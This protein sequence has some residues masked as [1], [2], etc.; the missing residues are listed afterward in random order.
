MPFSGPTN[1]ERIKSIFRAFNGRAEDM[2]DIGAGNGKYG[3]FALGLMPDTWRVGV[4]IT[5][6]YIAKYELETLYNE[7]LNIDA[8]QLM[9][10]PD[11]SWDLVC[12]GDVI[13][14]MRRSQAL[15]L[16]HFLAY[17][18]KWMLIAYPEKL[19]QNSWGGHVEEAHISSW[20]LGDFD[21]MDLRY[22]RV[23]VKRQ[24][25]DIYRTILLAQGFRES[26]DI[27]LDEIWI[28]ELDKQETNK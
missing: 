16:V 4:E 21:F 9:D 1:D 20:R 7:V 25:R 8:M 6:E 23:K 14:H 26:D 5:A 3:D 22:E 27:S 18:C 19:P 24:G 15:D 10:N 13:E 11:Q 17:R 28:P 12:L 2:L